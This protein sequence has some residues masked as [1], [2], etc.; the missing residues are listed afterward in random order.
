MFFRLNSCNPASA[1][2]RFTYRLFHAGVKVDAKAQS[3]IHRY[4]A[5]TL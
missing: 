4:E 1:K 2:E 5:D 3:T